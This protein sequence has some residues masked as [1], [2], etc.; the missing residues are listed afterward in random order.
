MAASSY[1]L[2]VSLEEQ[3]WSHGWFPARM[4][5]WTN[6][7]SVALGKVYGHGGEYWTTSAVAARLSVYRAGPRR[8]GLSAERSFKLG[9]AGSLSFM[10]NENEKIAPNT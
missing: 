10:E 7:L 3:G 4:N 1:A 9:V 6:R 2:A 5:K 8:T